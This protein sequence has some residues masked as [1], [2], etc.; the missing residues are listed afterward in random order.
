VRRRD[1][2]R[3]MRSIDGISLARDCAFIFTAQPS[4][5]GRSS[6]TVAAASPTNFAR[7]L[8]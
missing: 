7:V 2:A 4:L 3:F 5:S 1:V 6:V 8:R